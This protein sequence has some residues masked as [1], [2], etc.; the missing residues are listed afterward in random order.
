[1]PAIKI[2]SVFDPAFSEYGHV[3]EG[4]DWEI[5]LSKVKEISEKPKDSIYYV[6]GDEKLETL[7][8]AAEIKNR[9]YGGM[10]VQIGYCNGH[11]RQLGCLEY[12][13]G[14]EVD[15]A[16]DDVI[17]LLAPVQKIR[18]QKID[19]SEVEAFLLPAGTAVLLYE[20][21]LHY[22]PCTADGKDG[23]RVIVIL[24]KG[25]NQK[26]P[27]INAGNDEDKLLWAANKWLLA[28]P[29]SPE[30]AQGAWVGLTGENIVL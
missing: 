15:V 16:T 3:V 18:N 5:L 27:R 26:A 14:S 12:H 20:T 21:A 2:N 30:A 6:P 8:I 13:R 11:N 22:A 23:F 7:P 9:L 19:T 10:D 1:M 4:Y 25:T 28:H 17:L 24:P 29:D